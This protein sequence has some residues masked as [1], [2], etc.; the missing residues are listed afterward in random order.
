M[1]GFGTGL[2]IYS[3]ALPALA[4]QWR[5]PLYA[6]DSLGCGHM[7][8][9]IQPDVTIA[10]GTELGGCVSALPDQVRADTCQTR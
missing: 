4:E 5:G 1:H 3:A 8:F 10:F 2:G 6:I 7:R 9:R